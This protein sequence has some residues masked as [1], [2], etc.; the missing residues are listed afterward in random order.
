M[1]IYYGIKAKK[2]DGEFEEIKRDIEFMRDFIL[3]I[4]GKLLKSHIPHVVPQT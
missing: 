4:E 2:L 3:E 1:G